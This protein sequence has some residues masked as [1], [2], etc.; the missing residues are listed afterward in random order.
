[1]LFLNKCDILRAKLE[2]GIRLSDYIISYGNRPNDFES[3]SACQSG[4]IPV[5][6]TVLMS[7]LWFTDLRKKF[8]GLMKEH[9]GD[10]PFYC[11]F[12]SVTVRRVSILGEAFDLIRLLSGYTL[13]LVDIAEW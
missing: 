4:R 8:A 9:A 11:H 1:M 13:D 10:R 2:S 12:T 7:A 3:A 6:L 5:F